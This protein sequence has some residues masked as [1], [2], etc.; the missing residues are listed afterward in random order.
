M[1]TIVSTKY[2]VNIKQTLLMKFKINS[3]AR[4]S[5]IPP[6]GLE[7]EQTVSQ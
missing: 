2:Q 7:L 1:V 3:V 4:Y 6:L 5:S